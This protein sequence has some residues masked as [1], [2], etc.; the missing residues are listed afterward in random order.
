M[1]C[2]LLETYVNADAVLAHFTGPVVAELVPKLVQLCRI[3]RFV[4]D[5]DAGPQVTQ[6]AGAMG[7]EFFAYRG[8]LTR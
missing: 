1:R 8:G 5:G 2:R 3:D 6:M 4:I 7:A